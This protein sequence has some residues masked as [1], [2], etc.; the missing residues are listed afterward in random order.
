MLVKWLK[1][2]RRSNK[3]YVINNQYNSMA[4]WDK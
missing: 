4:G 1:K 2:Y 3:S